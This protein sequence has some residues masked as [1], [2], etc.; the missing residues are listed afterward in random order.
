MLL[1]TI[2]P[3]KLEL[4]HGAA[5]SVTDAAGSQSGS[6]ASAS[7]PPRLLGND[8]GKRVVHESREPDGRRG[9]FYVRAGRREG[10]DLRVDAGLVQDLCRYS[11]S[12]WPRTAT[13]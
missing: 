6:V 2:A 1:K 10:D 7:E 8:A 12:R 13:L 3:A 11:M 9:G 5:S 4:L